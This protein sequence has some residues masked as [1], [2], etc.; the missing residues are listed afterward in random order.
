MISRH[1]VSTFA[2]FKRPLTYVR[3]GE[4]I[5][6]YGFVSELPADIQL[7][8][9]ITQQPS[10][11]TITVEDAMAGNFFPPSK[12]DRVIYAGASHTVHS[13]RVQYDGEQPI[14]IRLVCLG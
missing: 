5:P 13:H 3:D 8:G 12:Y 14:F 11:V 7:T 4:Q 2:F 1:V 9:D 10:Y 6:T